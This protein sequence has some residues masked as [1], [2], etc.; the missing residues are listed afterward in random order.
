MNRR[1]SRIARRTARA[2]LPF[3]SRTRARIF[4]GQTALGIPSLK[5]G[6]PLLAQRQKYQRLQQ[7]KTRVIDELNARGLADEAQEIE[8]WFKSVA[9]P[10]S[11]FETLTPKT[12]R[13]I[14]PTHCPHCGAGIRPDEVEW[15]EA[16]LCISRQI[17]TKLR[18][19]L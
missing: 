10:A 7:V 11:E 15:L 8:A 1:G 9:P 4:A 2:A 5:R 14:L 17:D 12:K 16:A 19:D 13:P 6:L 18:S 3:T